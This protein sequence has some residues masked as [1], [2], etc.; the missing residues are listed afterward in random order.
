MSI[1]NRLWVL[2]VALQFFCIVAGG[3]FTVSHHKVLRRPMETVVCP[4]TEFRNLV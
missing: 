4:L 3:V 1:S 2:M